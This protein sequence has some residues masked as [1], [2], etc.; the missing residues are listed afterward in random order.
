ML[1]AQ[2]IGHGL[3]HYEPHTLPIGENVASEL[4]DKPDK[5]PLPRSLRIKTAQP[6][7]TLAHG[8]NPKADQVF[9]LLLARGPEA[10]A[11]YSS[12]V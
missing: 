6:L 3:D 12:A 11:G 1:Q 7:Q 9:G 8:S 4:R 5:K 10:H 2:P